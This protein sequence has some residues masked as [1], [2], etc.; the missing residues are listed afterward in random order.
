M[1]KSQLR[2]LVK[3]AIANQ[4]KIS[5][6][7]MPGGFAMNKKTGK[8]EPHYDNFDSTKL[9]DLLMGML[10]DE[11]QEN[12]EK[13]KIRRGNLAM[14]K[15]DIEAGKNTLIQKSNPENVAR[16]LRGEKPIY[17]EQGQ[18][19]NKQQLIDYLN[20]LPPEMK[21]AIPQIHMTGNFDRNAGWRTT[22]AKASQALSD[23]PKEGEFKLS[24]DNPTYKSI[25]LVQSDE[26]MRRMEKS[27]RWKD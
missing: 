21:V 23:T 14:D 13:E 3:E 18:T 7:V 27:V 16:I 4:A 24:Q 12:S 8:L 19:F 25:S 6:D 11:P 9:S 15:G 2:E 10:E 17:E 20:S 5:G 22:A 26:E 1:K